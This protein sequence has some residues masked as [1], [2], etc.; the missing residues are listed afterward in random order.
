MRASNTLQAMPP[1]W[2]KN[3][4]GLLGVALRFI[5]EPQTVAIDLNAALHDRGPGDQDIVRCRHRAV[6]LIGAEVRQLGAECF[7]PHDGVAAVSRMAEIERVSHL[8]NEAAD[9][10]L[11]AAKTVAGKDESLAADTFAPAVTAQNL[12]PADAA[13]GLR[14]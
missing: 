3:F 1:G 10:V 9:E 14:Q 2:R 5:A 11:I 6:A 8:G 4:R 7:P 13:V 12:H